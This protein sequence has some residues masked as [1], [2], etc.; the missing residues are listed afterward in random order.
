MPSLWL[1]L[2]ESPDIVAR[3]YLIV[4]RRGVLVWAVAVAVALVAAVACGQS[5]DEPTPSAVSSD[6]PGGIAGIV[7]DLDGAPVAGMRVGIVSGTAAFPEI[8]PETNEEGRYQIG[9]IAPGTFQ[10]GVHD[11]DGRRIGL[12]SV[13]V[14]SGET[15]SLDFS[16]S[17]GA[18]TQEKPAVAVLPISTPITTPIA[19][20]EPTEGR[21]CLPAGPLAVEVGDGWTISGPVSIPAEFPAELPHDATQW[22]S[23]FTVDAIETATYVAGRGSTPI[24]H[25]S[26]E[27]RVKTV[28]LDADGN[29]LSTEDNPGSWVPASVGNLGPVLTLD[30]ECH[31]KS[32]L[33]GWPSD[34]Q[35]SFS[36]RTL[37]SGATAVVFS[38]TQPLV[39][40]GQGIDATMERHH[41]YDK[42]TGRVALQEA[43]TTG[44]IN[45]SPFSM[46]MLQ[47][48]V[49]GGSSIA[50]PGTG[51]DS[52]QE[53][54]DLMVSFGEGIAEQR[55]VVTS[56]QCM[57][58]YVDS[59]GRYPSP[60]AS[61]ILSADSPLNL[62]LVAE[63]QPMAV[64]VR[65]YHGGGVEGSFLRWPEELPGGETPVETLR[66]TPSR[67][68]QFSPE[69]TSGEYSLVVRATWDGPVDVFYAMG[70]R[71]E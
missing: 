24:E 67:A 25:P 26:V 45:G 31:G 41:G 16:V 3:E 11:R 53:Y 10:V 58:S 57:S 18:A 1:G 43:R 6:G 44:T 63:S 15:A 50:P 70:L 17:V 46:E 39:I 55:A 5:S 23:T 49:P 52:C 21:L 48:L 59:T 69:A 61:S 36:E 8:A 28:T 64:D 68:F 37:S 35:P 34:A 13:V 22:S 38:V 4:S 2:Y 32:W 40:P 12:E 33:S 51:Q 65:L 62:R 54:L 27:L 66:P 42:A 56:Y 19:T 9:G 60:S 20:K 30:W 29:V 7:T 47:E 14:N 71:L